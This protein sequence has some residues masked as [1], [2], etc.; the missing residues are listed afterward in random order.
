MKRFI[1]VGNTVV[2]TDHLVA[3]TVSEEQPAAVKLVLRGDGLHHIIYN[4][5][6]PA[7]ALELFGKF[8][9]ALYGLV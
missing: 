4:C 3:V 9:T 8:K 5:P 1:D 7:E 2:N 6:T